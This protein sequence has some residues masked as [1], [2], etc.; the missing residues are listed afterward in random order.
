MNFFLFFCTARRALVYT[1]G[2]HLINISFLL[3]LLLLSLLLLLL[4]LSLLS[5]SSLFVFFLGER[6]VLPSS[7]AF[8]RS[9]VTIDVAHFSKLLRICKCASLFKHAFQLTRCF[10]SGSKKNLFYDRFVA[11]GVILFTVE[12]LCRAVAT[13]VIWDSSSPFYLKKQIFFAG[14]WQ[15]SLYLSSYFLFRRCG[16]LNWDV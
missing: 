14:W 7:E 11:R 8:F 3:L 5:S 9:K 4:L 12:G 1:R 16:V 13:N 6:K 15:T 2:S 10:L